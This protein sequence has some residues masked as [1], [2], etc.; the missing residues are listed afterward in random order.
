MGWYAIDAIDDAIDATRGFL[1][2]FS[3]GRWSRLALITLFLG[4]GGVGGQLS[5]VSN[6][7]DA[8]GGGMQN[9]QGGGGPG[10]ELPDGLSPAEILSGDGSA[11][12]PGVLPFDVTL[13]LV[14]GVA[15][16]LVGLWLVFGVVGAT[17]EFVFVD[18]LATDT[19]AIRGPFRRRLTDG[20]RLFVF[21]FGLSLLVTLPVVGVVAAALTGVVELGGIG[22]AQVVLGLLGFAVVAVLVGLVESF[23]NQFVV[24]VMI[25]VDETVLGGWGE[26]WSVLRAQP[27]QTVV[28]LVMHLLVGVGIGI[29]RGFL[30]LV[31]AIPVTIVAGIVGLAASTVAGTL[32]T[33]PFGVGVGLLVGVLTWL[34]AGFLLVL[35]PVNVL[36]K[37]YVRTYELRS[38]AGFDRR[39]ALLSPSLFDG[40]AAP[41]GDADGPG[42]PR[43]PGGPSGLG[44]S[45]S[46]SP[47][48]RPDG[49][50]DPRHPDSS[51]D[52]R[53]PD[54]SDDPRRP[55]NSGDRYESETG[56]FQFPDRESDESTDGDSVT[57]GSRADD[58]V[59]ATDVVDRDDRR[60]ESDG[61]NR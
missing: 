56:G 60:G 18:A 47:P 12:D 31:G 20:L 52:Q 40:G 45:D 24:P 22:L 55:D 13:G 5:N 8:F 27:K 43:G 59:D 41:A 1:A 57:G 33:G 28:Y 26:L 61:D 46:P 3:L 21:R 6:A 17:M 29:V 50:D 10:A 32:W 42:G 7:G 16:V 36:T 58:Y 11:V 2:P 54:S 39:F 23:T 38:L 25:A 51:D 15:A 30:L 19:V 53:R 9:G 44:S 4:T 37:T 35:L 49:P 14:L 48:R 34:A